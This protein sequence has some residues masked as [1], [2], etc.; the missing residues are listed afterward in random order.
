MDFETIET[1]RLILRKLTQEVYD[2]V[3][4]EL[5]DE[6]QSNFLGLH[7]EE[8]LR[9]EKWKHEHGLSTHNRKFAY[10][11]MI[12]K[13]S[14]RIIGWCGYHT[15]YVDHRRAEL[16]YGMAEDQ[17]KKKGFMTEAMEHIIPYGFE[18]MNLHRI[19]ALTATYNKASKAVLRKFN[20]IEEGIL[21]EHYVVNGKSEDSVMHALIRKVD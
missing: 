19:E 20:F 1:P 10:F 2:F 17:F 15:W 8:Q 7:S 12:E 11:Q 13:S 9:V 16:G 14:G 4:A 18:V 5:A 21:K 3:F 6:E